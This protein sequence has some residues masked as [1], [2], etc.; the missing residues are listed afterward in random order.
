MDAAPQL[1]EVSSGSPLNSRMAIGSNA[2]SIPREH[3]EGF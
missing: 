1:E 2:Q 3:N